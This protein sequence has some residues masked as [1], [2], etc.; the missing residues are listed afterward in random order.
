MLIEEAFLCANMK[1]LLLTYL[2]NEFLNALYNMLV[3]LEN[4][5]SISIEEKILR[6]IHLFK[7][8]NMDSK[9]AITNFGWLTSNPIPTAE[10]AVFLR[11]FN[12]IR[13][14]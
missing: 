14:S 8:C 13:K 7:S 11:R 3:E 5:V 1:Y 4:K 12:S 9:A 6:C 10:Y 2:L